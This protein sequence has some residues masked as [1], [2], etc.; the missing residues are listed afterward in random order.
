MVKKLISYLINI[1]NC[2]FN[3]TE[4]NNGWY[5]AS[6]MTKYFMRTANFNNVE[7]IFANR[8]NKSSKGSRFCK[9]VFN[10][11]NLEYVDFSLCVFESAYFI[12]LLTVFTSIFNSPI[13]EIYNRIFSKT[14][15]HI[16]ELI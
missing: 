7:L 3:E 5:R 14:D 2:C 8:K 13:I 1:H 10:G 9:V 12:I 11:C 4:F 6:Q 16:G 15:F